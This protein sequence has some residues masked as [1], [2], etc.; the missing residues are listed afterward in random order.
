MSK[1]TQRLTKKVLR[2]RVGEIMRDA[3][4][5]ARRF[6]LEGLEAL[7]FFYLYERA[8]RWAS[9]S[10]NSQTGLIFTPFLNPDYIRAV[11]AYRR[12]ERGANPFHKYIIARNTPDWVNVPYEEDL[13][14]KAQ[15]D[16]RNGEIYVSE[17]SLAS[18]AGRAVLAGI[19]TI[20][21]NTGKWSASRLSMPLLRTAVSGKKSL[22]LPWQKAS[23][24]LPRTNSLCFISFRKRYRVRLSSD[25]TDNN[26]H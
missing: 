7:D 9:G 8:R 18:L 4:R 13:I 11:Y 17:P 20:F 25:A 6:D 2:D 12:D 16:E 5:Q 10:L 24:I 14:K 19:T 26:K 22:T 3:Y 1:K 15:T 23:G 21:R